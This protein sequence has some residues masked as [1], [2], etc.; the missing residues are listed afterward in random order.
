MATHLTSE[1][2]APKSAAQHRNRG[3]RRRLVL[4]AAALVLT[5]A[6][7]CGDS[8]NGSIRDQ[9]RSGDGKGYVSGD[10]SIE[11]TAPERRRSP[12]QVTGTTLTGSP[13]KLST[14][15]GKVVVLNVWGSWCAPCVKEAP[16]LEAAWQRLRDKP[17]QFMG[18]NTRESTGNAAA[19]LSSRNITYPSLSDDGGR[20]LLALRGRAAT[21][22]TT[23]VLDRQGREAARVLGP[24]TA[25]TLTGLVTLSLIHI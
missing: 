23:L 3:P 11:V 21:V 8:Q 5:A 18:L 15:R 13:W 24:L 12:L 9:A 16:D 7:G 14:E 20:N 25:S 6:A 4:L 17:V 19:F 1:T 10:G 2:P 22:P